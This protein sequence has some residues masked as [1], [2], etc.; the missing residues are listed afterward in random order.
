MLSQL[1]NGRVSK[2]QI[3]NL[4]IMAF[5][6]HLTSQQLI[7]IEIMSFKKP[8]FYLKNEEVTTLRNK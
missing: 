5:P 3:S 6:K 7:E 8:I 4:R 1:S 2:L